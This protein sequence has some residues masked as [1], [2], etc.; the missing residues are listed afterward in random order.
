METKI[1]RNDPCP[2]GSGNKYKRCCMDKIKDTDKFVRLF[3]EYNPN[4][5]KTFDM[6][7]ARIKEVNNAMLAKSSIP[8]YV[9]S[10]F[11][12]AINRGL[13]SN[14]LSMMKSYFQGNIK[15]ITM[16]LSIRNVLEH[17]VMLKMHEKGDVTAQMEELFVEQYKIIEYNTYCNDKDGKFDSLLMPKLNNV[18]YQQ[19]LIVFSQY[20]DINKIDKIFKTKFPFMNNPKMNYNKLFE[21]YMPSFLKPYEY[22]SAV[23]HPTCYAIDTTDEFITRLFLKLLIELSAIYS[24]YDDCNDGCDKGYFV[25]HVACFAGYVENKSNITLKLYNLN[26]R[27]CEILI[28]VADYFDAQYNCSAYVGNF[29]REVVNIMKDTLGDSLLGYSDC[30]KIKFKPIVEMFAVF[31]RIY[32]SH[33][34]VENILS[35]SQSDENIFEIESNK[36]MNRY[37]LINT[38]CRNALE[39]ISKLEDVSEDCKS[40]FDNYKQLFPESE[41]LEVEFNKKFSKSL[42]YLIDEKGNVPTYSKIVQEF[43]S[44]VFF[45]GKDDNG[46]SGTDSIW[47]AYQESQSMSHANGYLYYSNEGAFKD[48]AFVVQTLDNFIINALNG[49]FN[50]F[51]VYSASSDE[52]LKFLP[53]LENAIE[54]FF[55]VSKEK[56]ELVNTPRVSKEF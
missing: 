15:S 42:G 3:R 20:M 47:M 54:E 49:V 51:S 40:S 33:N 44:D 28:N 13:S 6:L 26:C 8:D 31:Q 10:T 19:A 34:T 27:Q 29:L 5:I 52:N 14:A 1:G 48:D 12:D 11:C 53:V 23:I 36:S 32:C 18:L 2:C 56:I 37:A 41:I 39:K 4:Y 22:L 43:I 38:Y 35:D 30:A 9:G 24:N 45:A 21:K 17:C 46:I 55:A 25:E 16:M 50:L 7:Y